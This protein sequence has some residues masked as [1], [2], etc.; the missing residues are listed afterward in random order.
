MKAEVISRRKNAKM[1]IFTAL[2]YQLVSALV[3]LILPR[4]ILQTFGSD[5]NGIM[6]AVSQLL[7]Y[8]MV[9][10]CGIGGMVIAS[11]Y[12]PLADKDAEAV[13]DIFNN[14]KSFFKKISAVFACMLILLTFFSKVIIN[15][16]YD[17][18]YV[19]ALVLILG[20]NYYFS[21]YF[22]IAHQLL[23]KADQ[24]IHIVQ[25]VQIITIIINAI[26]CIAAIKAGLGIH[27]VKLLS[28]FVFLINPVVYRF[29]VK[30]HYAISRKIYDPH[31]EFPK[32]KEGIVHHVSYFIHRNTDIVLLSFFRGV[33][34]VSV[35][36]VYYSI[37][38]AV[39]NLLNAISTGLAGAI[40]NIIAKSESKLLEDSFRVYEAFNTIITSFF[41]TAVAILIVPF[42]KIYTYGVD[43]IN[44]IRPLFS[45]LL[46]LSQW[47]YC[48]RIPYGNV[49][50]AAGHYRQTKP[51]AYMEASVNLVISLILVKKYGLNGVMLGSMAAMFARTVYT[52][53]YLS[54]NI[55]YRKMRVFFREAGLNFLVGI[56]IVLAFN[57]FYTV[58]TLNFYTWIVDAV[59]V[60]CAVMF[61][62]LAAN[63]FI[64][65][66]TVSMLVKAI[67]KAVKHQ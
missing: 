19:G 13:S 20:I 6:Q 25:S 53:W 4:Y 49:V 29:Y 34:E 62:F 61:I 46:V 42:I 30:K 40:G 59:I 60:S 7:S 23:I 54:K 58:S 48:V 64:Y 27:A 5:V 22:G 21:Y 39:E 10:E 36:S 57:R 47:F 33:K 12:K 45:Y 1:N 8:T 56:I 3:G 17:S 15:T 44:Y 52:V 16:H 9:L 32:K 41:Y 18:V 63:V 31:R 11:F 38:F 37:A 43:D 2:L 14:T 26:V 35:Y 51:G 67:K 28:A 50:N 65:Y 55:L 66:D 24:K